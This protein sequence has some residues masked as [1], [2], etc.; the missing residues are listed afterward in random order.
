MD[1]QITDLYRR[2]AMHRRLVV[3]LLLLMAAP[4]CRAQEP[5]I[6]DVWPPGGERG[7]KVAARVEGGNLAGAKTVLISGHGVQAHMDTPAKDGGSIPL[8]LDIA[9]DAAPGP[10]DVRVV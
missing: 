10:Y 3:V 8:T 5:Q 6:A 4:R 7:S 9:S 1:L 2:G